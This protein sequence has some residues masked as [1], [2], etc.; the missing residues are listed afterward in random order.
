MA[1]IYRAIWD[2]LRRGFAPGAVLLAAVSL[3]ACGEDSNP[4]PGPDNATPHV[5]A[6]V[7]PLEGLVRPV[8]PPNTRVSLL[9]PPGRDPHG[10]ELRPSDVRTLAE[11]DLIVCVG[12]GFEPG[13]DRTIGKLPDARVVRFA[14]VEGVDAPA[15]AHHGHAHGHDEETHDH[16]GFDPHLWLDPD[17]CVRF[18]EAVARAAEDL[19]GGEPAEAVRTRAATH[20]DAIRA[21]DAELARALAPYE[22]S[23]IV[24]Q[25]AAFGRFAE[26]YGI[27]VVGVLRSSKNNA[28]GPAAWAGAAEAIDAARAEGVRVGV[29][30]EPQS[31]AASVRRL[32]DA[33]GAPMGR[34]DPLGSGDWFAMMR[35]I[36]AELARVLGA[37]Q[38][39]GD[40]TP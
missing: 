39:E 13:L 7:P 11:S 9:V 29:F 27:R 34:L 1:G 18:V 31:D 3:G 5:V 15:D 2:R 35:A 19:P 38:P 24:T 28:T 36:A 16:G 37:E 20:I 30:V 23:A 10:F 26:R 33:I 40:E 6:S 4:T 17:L 32:G 22:G 14:A 12:A 25:H 8:L 21:L